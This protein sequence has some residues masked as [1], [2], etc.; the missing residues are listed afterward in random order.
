MLGRLRRIEAQLRGV[1]AMIG[2]DD[3]RDS[4]PARYG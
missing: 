1:S 4:L 2:K 3:D